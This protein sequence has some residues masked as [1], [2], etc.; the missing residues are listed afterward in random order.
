MVTRC[1][2]HET[3]PLPVNHG[4]GSEWVVCEISVVGTSLCIMSWPNRYYW[5]HHHHTCTLCSV[6]DTHTCF[7]YWSNRL[8]L[9]PLHHGRLQ[10]YTASYRGAVITVCEHIYTTPIAQIVFPAHIAYHYEH[11]FWILPAHHVWIEIWYM[12][13]IYR[14]CQH[15]AALRYRLADASLSLLSRIQMH[16]LWVPIYSHYIADWNNR[17]LTRAACWIHVAC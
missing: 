6:L 17:Q 13:G 7:I 12:P 15:A 4:C 2:F 11:R 10:V 9:P 8:L 14:L 5:P 16:Q 1:E 3:H